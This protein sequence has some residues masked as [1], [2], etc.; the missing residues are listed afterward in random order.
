MKN[1][2][3]KYE[4]KLEFLEGW[5]DTLTK[6]I[7][8]HGGMDILWNHT[9]PKCSVKGLG[10]LYITVFLLSALEKW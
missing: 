9:L 7:T 8:L 4:A 5:G 2:K 3:E 1:S 10:T 6:K